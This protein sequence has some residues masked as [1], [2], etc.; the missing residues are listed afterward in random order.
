MTSKDP[1]TQL[2]AGLRELLR[3]TH[4]DFKEEAIGE[5]I[6]LIASGKSA[7]QVNTFLN[8]LGGHSSRNPLSQRQ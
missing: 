1:F 4:L 3:T 2:E 8:N 7:A 5:V 6:A